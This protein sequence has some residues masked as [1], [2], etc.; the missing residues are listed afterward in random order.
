MAYPIGHVRGKHV[1]ARVSWK[2][3]D[4][5]QAQCDRCSW[6]VQRSSLM[7]QM[8]YRGGTSPVPTGIFVCAHCYDVPNP[9]GALNVEVLRQDPV[10]VMNP[11]P[12]QTTYD[13]T[14]P[15]Y[16]SGSLPASALLPPGTEIYVTGLGPQS[17]LAYADGFT[18]RNFETDAVVT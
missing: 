1:L 6:W 17:V 16:A 10:P 4:D 9:Q 5:A 7:E 14:I 3:R 18:W 11:R 8:E 15:S 2:G 12:D 13:L